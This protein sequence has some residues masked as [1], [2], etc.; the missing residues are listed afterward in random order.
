VGVWLVQDISSTSIV[1]QV[2]L[3]TRSTMTAAFRGHVP[4]AV[5]TSLANLVTVTPL[6]SRNIHELGASNH[7]A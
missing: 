6:Y 1:R 4:L 3:R 5:L 2:M 7:L